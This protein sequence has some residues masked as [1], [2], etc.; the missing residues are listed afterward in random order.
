MWWKTFLSTTGHRN[1]EIKFIWFSYFPFLYFEGRGPYMEAITINQE[2]ILSSKKGVISQWSRHANVLLGFLFMCHVADI[3]A[4]IKWK[5]FQCKRLSQSRRYFGLLALIFFYQNSI[6]DVQIESRRGLFYD[7]RHYCRQI[8]IYC[9]HSQI[10]QRVDI[11]QCRSFFSYC[12]IQSNWL[13]FK[14]EVSWFL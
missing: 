8:Q 11:L 10:F 3:I 5:N 6:V 12:C 4:D 1:A 9:S 2:T 13:C 7:Y 14:G